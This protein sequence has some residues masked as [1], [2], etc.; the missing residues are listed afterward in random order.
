MFKSRNVIRKENKQIKPIQRLFLD[1][2]IRI[3]YDQKSR[4][5][6]LYLNFICQKLFLKNIVPQ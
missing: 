4:K 3:N 1:F 6:Y 5:M 2:I